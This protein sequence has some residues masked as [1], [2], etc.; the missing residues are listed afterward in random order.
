MNLS[1]F[2]SNER[3]RVANQSIGKDVMISFLVN[4]L[5]SDILDAAQRTY[6]M[7]CANIAKQIVGGNRLA[8]GVIIPVHQIKP[9]TL[10]YEFTSNGTKELRDEIKNENHIHPEYDDTH[11]ESWVIPLADEVITRS[12]KYYKNGYKAE[13]VYGSKMAKMCMWDIYAKEVK[14]LLAQDGISWEFRVAV[15]VWKET[16]GWLGGNTKSTKQIKQYICLDEEYSHSLFG[17]RENLELQLHYS[18]TQK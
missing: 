5:I 6:G 16:G 13:D 3:Q 11:G 7:V 14:R 10:P 9:S 8:T 1:D 12:R 18:Y 17:K 15:T 2:I 4:G